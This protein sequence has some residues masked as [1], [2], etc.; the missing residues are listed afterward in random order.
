MYRLIPA[1]VALAAL[2]ACVPTAAQQQYQAISSSTQ[3][4]SQQARTCLQEVYN[5][6]E[7]APIRPH[8]A[9]NPTAPT[10]AQ[11]SDQSL[12]TPA[13]AA[14]IQVLY[15]RYKA[16]QQIV[17]DGLTRSMP[18]AASALQQ[19]Y[20]AGDDDFML[21]LQRKISWGEGIRRRRDRAIALA[22]MLQSQGQQMIAALQQQHEAEVARREAAAAALANAAATFN[23]MGQPSPVPYGAYTVPVPTMTTCDRIGTQINCLTH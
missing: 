22:A 6:P 1:V 4:L 19:A 14:A 16:C 10:L 15:P 11:L 8:W 18:A 23:A 5:A 9:I 12:A 21:L 13:E 7:A 17:F 2:A 20:A 3:A